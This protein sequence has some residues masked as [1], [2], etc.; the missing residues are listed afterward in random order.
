[1]VSGRRVQSKKLIIRNIENLSRLLNQNH[2]VAV[3]AQSLPFIESGAG[4]DIPGGRV[5][6]SVRLA[7]KKIS[8]VT[9]S[10][11]HSCVI[12]PLHHGHRGRAAHGPLMAVFTTKDTVKTLSPKYGPSHKCS[13]YKYE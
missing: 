7:V 2:F 8:V 4:P 11:F 12:A 13:K 1:M 9:D 5:R 6:V 3:L 10:V